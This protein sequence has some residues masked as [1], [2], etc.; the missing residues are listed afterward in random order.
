MFIL[1]IATPGLV[2]NY[3]VYGLLRQLESVSV[4][5]FYQYRADWV[6]KRKLAEAINGRGT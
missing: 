1:I 4:L 2:Q 6:V 5:I 3:V